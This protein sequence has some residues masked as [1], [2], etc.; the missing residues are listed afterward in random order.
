MV[1]KKKFKDTYPAFVD[2]ES[3]ILSKVRRMAP[4]GVA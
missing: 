4:G 2:F 3:G 1:E